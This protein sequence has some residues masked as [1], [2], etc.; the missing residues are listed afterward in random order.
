MEVVRDEHE[1]FVLLLSKL[2]RHD[3]RRCAGE[4]QI[5]RIDDVG[6]DAGRCGRNVLCARTE[7]L[8]RAMDQ[9]LRIVKGRMPRKSKDNK[10]R[11]GLPQ[12]CFTQV[13]H[14]AC[15]HVQAKQNCHYIS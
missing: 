3:T 14:L 10:C 7:F 5:A 8:F 15:F 6:I 4:E 13:I 11:D 2:S 12:H 1:I 9:V